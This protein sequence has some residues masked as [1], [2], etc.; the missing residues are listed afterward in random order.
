M[1]VLEVCIHICDGF[2]EDILREMEKGDDV[3]DV[4]D[5]GFAEGEVGR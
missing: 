1:F 5:C 3:P 4:E 2:V